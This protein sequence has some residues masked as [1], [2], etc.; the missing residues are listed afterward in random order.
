M[1][2]DGLP[3]LHWALGSRND[4]MVGWLLDQGCDVDVRSFEGATALMSAIQT[5]KPGQIEQLLE[6]KADVNARDA[7]GFTALHRA[8]EY[9]NEDVVRLLLA[10]GA[11]RS[12]EAE[13]Y[14]AR[15]LAEQRNHSRL[16]QLL[17]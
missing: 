12:I 14:T 4:G 1:A 2:K 3:A 7:R 17:Q 11:D 15:Y 5:P 6:R 16:A 13:G 8:A 10:K 9:G